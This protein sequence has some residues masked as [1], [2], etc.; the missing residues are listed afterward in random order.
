VISA[1]LV[2]IAVPTDAH[3]VTLHA[4]PTRDHSPRAPPCEASC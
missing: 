4:V 2:R 3:R 1:P